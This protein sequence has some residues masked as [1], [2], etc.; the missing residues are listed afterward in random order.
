MSWVRSIQR[1]DRLRRNREETGLQVDHRRDPVSPP[2]DKPVG[3]L[4]GNEG[5]IPV[6]SLASRLGRPFL[7]S[8]PAEGGHGNSQR[9][10]VLNPPQPS[11]QMGVGEGMRPWAL[12]VDRV[13]QVSQVQADQMMP[14]PPIPVSPH[15]DY[16]ECI[17]RVDERLILLLSPERLHPKATADFSAPVNEAP[18]P[19]AVP[20]TSPPEPNS[21]GPHR[22]HSQIVVFQVTEPFPT[23]RATSL[24]LSISQVRE[25]AESPPIIPLPGAPP[26]VSGIV[27][28]RGLPV[29]IIDIAERLGLAQAPAG[30]RTRLVIARDR[31]TSGK[32]ALVGLISRPAIRLLRLPIAHL[33]SKRSLDLDPA[34]TRGVFELE[35][36][37]LVIPDIQ[38]IL[39]QDR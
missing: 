38:G 1:T 10:V 9:I 31:G 37:T 15:T 22:S 34:L 3:W 39:R 2:D 19:A 8:L 36:E 16:F 26:Y 35:S 12:L 21:I 14:L 29:P 28:W 32:G 13:S 18:N 20:G 25:V 4:P 24:G 17:V 33:L 7:S 27:D 11:P 5:E 23:E 6:F 30:R